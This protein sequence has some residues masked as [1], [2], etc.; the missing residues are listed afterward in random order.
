MKGIRQDQNIIGHIVH[1]VVIGCWFV[2][3]RNAAGCWVVVVV[4]VVATRRRSWKDNHTA[5]RLWI[6]GL[7]LLFGEWMDGWM[8]YLSESHIDRP[9]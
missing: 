8:E 9:I 3:K 5:S 2:G 4:V 1:V 7:I 6:A